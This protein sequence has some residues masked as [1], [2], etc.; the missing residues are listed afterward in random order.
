MTSRSVQ[1][2]ITKQTREAMGRGLEKKD[3]RKDGPLFPSRINRARPMTTRQ[4]A[5]LL[6]SWLRALGLDP[7]AYG[8]HS[9]R[10]TKA[11]MI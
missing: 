7:L 5:L 10:R 4:Y 3:L 2:K 11:S 6:R 9:L 1:F 8:T